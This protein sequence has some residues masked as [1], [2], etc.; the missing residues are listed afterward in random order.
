MSIYHRVPNEL[1]LTDTQTLLN[2]PS[3]SSESTSTSA[4]MST[5][6]SSQSDGVFSRATIVAPPGTTD[7]T[8]A[9][10]PTAPTAPSV[11]R[12]VR[13]YNDRWFFCYRGTSSEN[14]RIRQL[15]SMAYLYIA[16]IPTII[17]TF[18]FVL[19]I[20]A[21]ANRADIS[22]FYETAS[23]TNYTICLPSIG[24]VNNPPFSEPYQYLY[25][26]VEFNSIVCS[27]I[28]YDICYPN[29]MNCKN[30][31]QNL[32]NHCASLGCC[33]M[34]GWFYPTWY[35]DDQRFQSNKCYGVYFNPNL[36][37]ERHREW[38][39]PII[40]LTTI[41]TL[42]CLIPHIGNVLRNLWCP[43]RPPFENCTFICCGGMPNRRCC[44]CSTHY[45]G[46]MEPTAP[47]GATTG[48]VERG[49]GVGSLTPAL[50]SMQM[51][52]LSQLNNM[53]HGPTM[54]HTIR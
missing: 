18:W 32:K 36:L 6:V 13:Y 52:Q 23:P 35:Y 19:L 12:I 9:T 28:K 51:L 54:S 11:P 20:D 31:L 43:G 14:Q 25:V 41:I 30:E 16:A 22:T 1:E 39:I 3:T 40:L 37:M 17:L 45:D 34:Q 8:G 42:A 27:P 10:A 47:A 4:P 33:K 26:N 29:R 48:D 49:T 5:S 24:E 2:Q 53:S 15:T 50:V 46:I 44:D 21:A 38:L 7:T